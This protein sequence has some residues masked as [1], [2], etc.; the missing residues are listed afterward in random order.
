MPQSSSLDPY[1][2]DHFPL[3]TSNKRKEEALRPRLII[4]LVT[5]LPG[6]GIGRNGNLG[7]VA[8]RFC[9]ICSPSSAN[10]KTMFGGGTW[11][12]GSCE[13]KDVDSAG[14]LGSPLDG[15]WGWKRGRMMRFSTSSYV[16]GTLALED[17]VEVRASMAQS[18]ARG[19]G[20]QCRSVE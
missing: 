2:S 18:E 7:S 10:F 20:R 15:A 9:L 6:P 17:A 13:E 1:I 4:H 14:K 5:T 8:K 19:G 11:E 12:G 16:F 3:L